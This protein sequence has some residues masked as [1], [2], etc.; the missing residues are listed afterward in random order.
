[1]FL[2]F[3][4]W[5]LIQIFVRFYCFMMIGVEI[6]LIWEEQSLVEPFN[7]LLF[8]YKSKFIRFKL[9]C[10]K[11][12]I[13]NVFFLLTQFQPF[14]L[15]REQIRASLWYWKTGEWAWKSTRKKFLLDWVLRCGQRT[16]F[17]INV[18][19]SLIN[20]KKKSLKLELFERLGHLIHLYWVRLI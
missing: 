11:N 6:S 12:N 9:I 13:L 18:I 4:F 10:I 19:P 2:K 20:N 1:M 15:I 17:V 14:G 16:A 8:K 7:S 3:L 5:F